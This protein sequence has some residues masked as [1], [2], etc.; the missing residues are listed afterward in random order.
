LLRIGCLLTIVYSLDF[1]FFP[2]C[3]HFLA[4]ICMCHLYLFGTFNRRFS[5]TVDG[6][7][8]VSSRDLSHRQCDVS[9]ERMSGVL[10]VDVT[11]SFHINIAC[12]AR[13]KLPRSY[14]LLCSCYA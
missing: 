5:I 14:S 7:V 6:S 10:D 3:F 9:N 12:F 2:S 1:F 8:H 13:D 11:W 4:T